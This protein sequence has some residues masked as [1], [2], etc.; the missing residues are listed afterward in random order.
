MIIEYPKTRKCAISD[1]YV[2]VRN[3]IS[4]E[5]LFVSGKL[6]VLVVIG[7]LSGL[8]KWWNTDESTIVCDVS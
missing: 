2:H 6:S 4:L 3:V 7:F 5:M 8:G 1:I